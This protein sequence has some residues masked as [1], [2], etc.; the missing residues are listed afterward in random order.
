MRWIIGPIR[1]ADHRATGARMCWKPLPLA[2]G[3][4]VV[5]LTAAPPATA[6]RMVP[7]VIE[8]DGCIL[9]SESC[10][11]PR[12]E[13]EMV[14]DDQKRKFAVE[15]LRFVSG[16]AGSTGKLLTEIHL[17]GL[18]VQGPKELTERLVEPGSRRRV[19]G[20]LRL[21]TRHLLLQ[22]VEPLGTRP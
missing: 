10:K 16:V 9:P 13:V 5:V 14:V 21:E 12:E 1:H 3:L 22:S 11:K 18:R 19:R 2:F 7:P 15:E 17:R 20:L 8:L 6:R 4:V